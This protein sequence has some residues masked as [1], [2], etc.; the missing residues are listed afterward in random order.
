MSTAQYGKK[1]YETP[2][3]ERFGTVGELTLAGNTNPATDMMNGSADPV[4]I[5]VGPRPR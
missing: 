5:V 2:R 1:S 4:G 3:L